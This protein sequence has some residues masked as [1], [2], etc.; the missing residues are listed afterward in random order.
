MKKYRWGIMFLLLCLVLLGNP[1]QGVAAE[2]TG[3]TDKETVETIYNTIPLDDI[4]RVLQDLNEEEIDFSFRQYVDEVIQG[5]AELSLDG[6]W[7][8]VK[9]H[10]AYEL[11]ENRQTVY[12]L[13]LCG[14]LSGIFL[15][16]ST[17]LYEKQMGQTSFYVLFF[18][19]STI[20]LSGFLEA[21]SVATEVLERVLVFMKCL[22]PAFSIA[23]T[24]S[25]G[26]ST[27]MAFYQ[28][29]LIAIGVAENVLISVF[30]P[31]VKVYFLIRI[32]N[33]LLEGRFARMA[34]LVSGFIRFGTK[35]ILMVMVGHQGIQ[36]LITP[37][38]DGVKRG[39]VFRAATSL[40]GVGNVFG[41]V[42]DTVIGT[43]VLIKSA[44]GVGGLLTICVLCV[45]PL[46]RLWMYTIIYKVLAAFT[47]PLTDQ[48]MVSVFQSASD[49]GR[50]LVNIVFM[51]A[52]MFL[53]TLTIVIAATNQIY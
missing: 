30:L 25:A 18:F 28:G 49:S 12:R 11:K 29:A 39:A 4:E 31:L 10:A 14:V 43:G 6:I 21:V 8:K 7:D 19:A 35:A 36:G 16:F 52:V 15:N 40:P 27:S 41:G 5:R 53:L 26:S 45:V 42:T 32:V 2:E 37:A 23:L 1:V 44:I 9:E 3:A 47:Q 22:L 38:L 46:V 48:R 33:P 13:L 17:S 20:M 51:T 24:W 34:S 50:L